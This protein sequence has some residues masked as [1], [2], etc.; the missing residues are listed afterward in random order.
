MKLNEVTNCDVLVIGSGAAGFSAA[1]TARYYGLNVLMVEKA[2]RF[3]GST[4][5]SGG[6]LWIPSNPVAARGGR[7][8]DIENARIYLKHE[9]SDLFD[10][11]KTNAYL[12]Y[13]P[14]MVSFFEENTALSFTTDYDFPDYHPDSPG[15]SSGGRSICVEAFDGRELGPAL[16]QLQPQMPELTYL[17]LKIGSGTDLKHF[18]NFTRSWR[19]A[20]F[21]MR[22]FLFH[23]RDMIVHGRPLRLV[24][25]GA[26][27]GRLA[28]SAFD[29]KIPLWLSAPAEELVFESDA[30]RGAIVLKDGER[31][32]VI[33]RRGVVLATGGFPQDESRRKALYP[34]ARSGATNVSI[35]A[36]PKINSGDGLRLAEQ[37]GGVIDQVFWN[38]GYMTPVSHVPLPGG[39]S[40]VYPHL[41]DRGKPGVIAVTRHGKRFTNESNP[42]HDVAQAICHATAHDHDQAVF[43]ICDHR[44]IRRYGLGYAKPFPVPLRS[45]LCSGYL[46]KSAT[47]ESLARK[48]GIDSQALAKTIQEFNLHARE[49]RDPQFSKGSNAYNRF[50]GDALHVPNPCV[51]P[52]ERPPFYAVR[53]IAGDMATL[54]GL[55]TNAYG[56]VLRS[57]G[58]VIQGLY[59]V[60]ND[61]GNIMKGTCLG[62]GATIG[63]AM[64]F[65]Y[66]AGCHLAEKFASKANAT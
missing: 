11:E 26:L 28:K 64:T 6:W 41:T 32:R 42:Y 34:K 2:A 27:I 61:M 52:I 8:D 15:A 22:H 56:Q 9:T 50:Q 47:I 43:F 4:A 16:T 36:A 51:A 25:G 33:A 12:E 46:V 10:P 17:G 65:G 29:A 23:V 44:A 55:K 45:Y 53:V 66:I 48:V 31:R 38:A 24:N 59:A 62:A 19:S 1:I 14:H 63:P 40:G 37:V 5:W 18:F 60:G 35:S 54:A 7:R 49:G 21:V 30:V 39:A 58:Q 13:G 20:I 3:G 57:D